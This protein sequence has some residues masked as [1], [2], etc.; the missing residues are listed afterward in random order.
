MTVQTR[1]VPIVK[2]W[3][4]TLDG[5]VNAQIR[6]QVTGYLLRQ[7]YREGSF[8]RKGQLLFEIDPIDPA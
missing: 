7:C 1:D 2:E 8:V 3:V 5:R 4:G 6:G